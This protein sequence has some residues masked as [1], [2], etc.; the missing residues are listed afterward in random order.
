MYS[1]RH[2]AATLKADVLHKVKMCPHYQIRLP[3]VQYEL[4]F[5]KSSII[6]L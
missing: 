3:V 2:F 6:I 1:L 4:M 5:F